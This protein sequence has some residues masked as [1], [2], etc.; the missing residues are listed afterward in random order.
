MAVGR[1][2]ELGGLVTISGA[3]VAPPPDLIV[4]RMP[5]HGAVLFKDTAQVKLVNGLSR[6]VPMQEAKLGV[7]KHFSVVMRD[8][9][10]GFGAALSGPILSG[11]VVLMKKGSATSYVSITPTLTPVGGSGLLDLALTGGHLDTLGVAAVNITG[12]GVLPNDD[13]FIDVVAV[14]KNDGVRGGMTGLPN[15]VAG[16]VGGLPTV[17]ATIPNATAGTSFGLALKQDVDDAAASAPSAIL[18]ALLADHSTAGTV[19][20]GIAIA[21]G[22]LQGNFMLDNA[23]ND[24]NG[25]T[26][27][28]LRIWRDSSE[29]PEAG[30]GTGE[31]EFAEFA[32]TTSYTGPGKVLVHRVVR[33]IGT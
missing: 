1:H 11:L 26:S 4:G 2:V 24:A 18:D 29:V 30:G 5:M 15:A 33:V 22:L 6:G 28:R 25:M 32:V 21:A 10:T 20:D 14:D 12:P 17:G 31:G 9:A 23:T 8:P 27:A 13:L 3:I 7:A 16:A 19:A